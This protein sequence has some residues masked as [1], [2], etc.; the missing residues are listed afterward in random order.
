[1]CNKKGYSLVEVMTVVSILLLVF[2]ITG[3]MIIN[4]LKTT[5]YESE[6]A[7]AVETARK[8]MDIITKDIRGAN[9]SEKGDYP[10]VIAQDDELAFFNDI[11]NDGLME[12]IRYYLEGTELVKEIFLPGSLMDYS[13]FSAS[14]TVA[15]YVNNNGDPIFSYYDYNSEENNLINNIRMVKIIIVINVTPTT[16]P[17]DYILESDVNLRNLKNY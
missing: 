7:T 8:S 3:D 4:S 1:M 6:Q 16:L 17:N 5:R 9:T 11:N 13:I 14:S 10:L 12:K 2:L 15:D